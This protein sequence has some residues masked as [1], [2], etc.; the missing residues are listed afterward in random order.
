ME[1]GKVVNAEMEANVQQ[2]ITA[3]VNDEIVN[4]EG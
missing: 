4:G 2:E 3:S 1:V